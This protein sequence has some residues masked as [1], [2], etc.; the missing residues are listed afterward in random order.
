MLKR[1]SEGGEKTDIE[2]RGKDGGKTAVER[3]EMEAD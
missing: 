1:V 3:P 2:P